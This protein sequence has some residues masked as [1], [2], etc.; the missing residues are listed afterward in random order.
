[1]RPR[2]LIHV[3]LASFCKQFYGHPKPKLQTG[4]PLIPRSAGYQPAGAPATCRQFPRFL[5]SE[6]APRN[7]KLVFVAPA[8]PHPPALR[9]HPAS[10]PPPPPPTPPPPA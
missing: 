3:M 5:N 8:A 7:S 10:P 4:R 2:F 1:M 9:P 6:F